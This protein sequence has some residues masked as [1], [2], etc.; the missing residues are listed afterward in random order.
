MPC[1]PMVPLSEQAVTARKASG[2]TAAL[3]ALPPAP[4]RPAMPAATPLRPFCIVPSTTWDLHVWTGSF[5][6][7]GNRT[8]WEATCPG[9]EH[10][11]NLAARLPGG[12]PATNLT[13]ATAEIG[14]AHV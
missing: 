2:A 7:P 10:R 1:R 5:H 3:R 12:C 11:A 4:S 6:H 8:G 14:R 13:A 9:P